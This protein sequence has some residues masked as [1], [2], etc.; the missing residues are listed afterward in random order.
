MRELITSLEFWIAMA[1]A[2][3]LK[4]RASPTI[5]CFG[6]I[7][8]TVSAVACALVFTQPL[9]AWLDLDGETYTYAVSALIAL[10]GEH[11][12]RQILSLGIEDAFRLW[13]GK[14]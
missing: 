12:S 13:R 10:T 14:K 2:I 11:I 8:T 4:L 9:V 7:A 6:A 5:T 3:A 1:A